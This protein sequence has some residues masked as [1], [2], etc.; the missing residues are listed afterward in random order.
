MKQSFLIFTITFLMSGFYVNGQNWTT[1]TLSWGN[2]LFI[3]ELP[4]NFKRSTNNY[5]EGV[6]LHYIFPDSSTV[7]IFHG[8]N[9]AVSLYKQGN[10]DT[11]KVNSNVYSGR[12]RPTGK[13]WKAVRKSDN[14]IYWYNLVPSEQEQTF[15]R[16]LKS[17][18]LK[19]ERKGG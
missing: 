12:I 14:L 7:T 3:T 5:T 2:K 16:V 17:F 9:A 19:T 4:D 13:L 15:D 11:L 6:F 10:F 8:W 18:E 1:D